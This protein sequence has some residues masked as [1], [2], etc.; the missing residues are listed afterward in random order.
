M[1]DI[2]LITLHVPNIHIEEAIITI[3]ER[4]SLIPCNPFRAE[5]EALP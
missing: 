3:V 2:S 1:I 4:L 5:Q